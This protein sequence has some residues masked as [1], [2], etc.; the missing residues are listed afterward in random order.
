MTNAFFIGDELTAAGFRL[1]GA[2]GRTPAEADIAAAFAEALEKAELVLITS[3]SAA[4]L[5]TGV[6]ERA[7][8]RASP[9]VL[10]VPGAVSGE[11]PPDL[12]D[13]VERALGI[14]P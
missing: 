8:R 11:R 6:L 12:G 5:D 2:E 4:L 1:A 7:V 3:S 14:A 9:M 10:V 13:A